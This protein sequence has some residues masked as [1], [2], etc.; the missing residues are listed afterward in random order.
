L[1]P[2]LN[3]PSGFHLVKIHLFK[4]LFD[5]LSSTNSSEKRSDQTVCTDQLNL[6]LEINQVQRNQGN[7]CKETTENEAVLEMDVLPESTRFTL[8]VNSS[9]GLSA[10]E[11]EEI[12]INNSQNV[13][14]I[15]ENS[16][17]YEEVVIYVQKNSRLKLV[18]LAP[19]S[20]MDEISYEE[21]IRIV[22]I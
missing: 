19:C 7:I 6:S 17:F 16:N 12:L 9:M 22:I 20:I 1:N 21:I 13:A 11:D 15:D 5:R 18:L 3:L 2:D 4:P 8:N 14:I 10:E